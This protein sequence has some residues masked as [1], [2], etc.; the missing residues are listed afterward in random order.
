[1]AAFRTP[2]DNSQVKSKQGESKFYMSAQKLTQRAR[3][4][5]FKKRSKAHNFKKQ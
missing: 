1:M 2:L 4:I 3:G 5:F